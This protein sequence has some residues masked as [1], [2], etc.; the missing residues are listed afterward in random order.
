MLGEQIFKQAKI[1][2]HLCKFS[3]LYVLANCNNSRQFFN[4]TNLHNSFS[5]NL[6][7]PSNSHS[8]AAAN[9]LHNKFK[10]SCSSSSG[11]HWEISSIRSW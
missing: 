5:H 6:F 10:K 2:Q 11:L 7:K 1:R 9:N 8:S 3:A 4:E